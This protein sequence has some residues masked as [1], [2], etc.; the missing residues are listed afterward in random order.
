MTHVEM[1]FENEMNEL[2]LYKRYVDDI[3]V[4]TQSEINKR[5]NGIHGEGGSS[6]KT[7]LDGIIFKLP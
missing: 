7:K 6:W 2:I 3:F 1:T 5:L 4:I